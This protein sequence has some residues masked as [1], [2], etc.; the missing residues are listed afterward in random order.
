MHW[1]IAAQNIRRQKEQ[2]IT[3]SVQENMLC[4][5]IPRHC[6]HNS[7]QDISHKQA[8]VNNPIIIFFI[9]H[10]GKSYLSCGVMLWYETLTR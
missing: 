10:F 2:K 6:D 5:Y 7:C 3:D 8:G 9:I 1:V 4:R